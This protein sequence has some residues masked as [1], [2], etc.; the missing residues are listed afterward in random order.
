VR[1]GGFQY[2]LHTG[3][4][5]EELYDLRADPQALDDLTLN[6]RNP[7]EWREHLGLAHNVLVGPGWRV[8]LGLPPGE[9][10]TLKLPK[11]CRVAGVIDPEAFAQRRANQVW[12]ETPPVLTDDVATVLVS[13]DRQT[14]TITT[15]TAGSGTL[16]VLFDHSTSVGGTLTTRDGVWQVREGPQVGVPVVGRMDVRP[17][18]VIQPPKGEAALIEEQVGAVPSADV[19]TRELLIRL[20]YMKEEAP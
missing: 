10:V 12:G 9:T 2:I 13:E 7:D 4:G 14:L 17:G 8:E 5:R 1:R 15:G 20:G 16:Y 18:T 3:S 19:S 6:G 11:P